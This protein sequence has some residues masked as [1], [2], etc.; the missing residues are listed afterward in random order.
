MPDIGGG[1]RR[2]LLPF[3]VLLASLAC[4]DHASAEDSYLLALTWHPAFCE[5]HAARAECKAGAK[6]KPRLVLH[7]LWPD[8]DVN[9]YGKRNA[10]DAFC[11][12]DRNAMVELDRGNWLKMPP[13]ELSEAG[14]GD[15][16]AAM[17][18]TATGLD[19]HE[20][21]KHGTCSGLIA[22]DYFA[23]AIALLREVERGSLG[24]LLVDEA[25][26]TVAR[27]RLLGAFEADFGYGTSRALVL[28]CTRDGDEAVLTE[29]RIRLKRATVAQG[30]TADN[31]AIPPKAPRGDCGAEVEIPDWRN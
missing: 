5:R 3:L 25:G 10:G 4:S 28:D 7:G 8:W 31:L 29:I 14:T 12:P 17:P 16:R 24:R 18:G 22:A 27:K 19:R 13:I 9:G 20:W 11:S 23:A 21:W 1:V 6:A 2:A 26:G 30:L 15:L